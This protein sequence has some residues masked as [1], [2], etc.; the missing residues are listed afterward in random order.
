MDPLLSKM[1][2]ESMTFEGVGDSADW[3]KI[4]PPLS[5]FIILMVKL[6]I[7]S[8]SDPTRLHCP[9]LQ[10]LVWVETSWDSL[11]VPVFDCRW[12]PG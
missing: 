7:T 8:A 5:Q 4:G 10:V 12:C 2:W 6:A 9:L 11:G 1:I 3:C